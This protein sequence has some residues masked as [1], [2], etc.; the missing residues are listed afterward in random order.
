MTNWSP[1]PS[2]IEIFL[3]F[4][5]GLSVYKG[6]REQRGIVLSERALEI[7]KGSPNYFFPD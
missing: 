6:R 2:L 1:P 4:E 7:E 3:V 5:T